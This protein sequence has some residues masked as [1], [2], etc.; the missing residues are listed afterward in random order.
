MFQKACQ[1]IRF[2]KN[3]VYKIP[4]GGAKPLVAHSLI[5]HNLKTISNCSYNGI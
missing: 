3:I 2:M 5:Q 1:V 4:P